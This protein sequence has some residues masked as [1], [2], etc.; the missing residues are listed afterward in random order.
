MSITR[1]KSSACTLMIQGTT[2]GAGKSVLGGRSLPGA[3]Q[4][5]YQRCA[6]LC[7]MSA[8]KFN[9]LRSIDPD[10]I[11]RPTPRLLMGAIQLCEYLD[12]ARAKRN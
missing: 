6:I 3:G 7:E 9:D 5:R 10:L 11:S 4:S 12:E 2:S 1:M 8:V